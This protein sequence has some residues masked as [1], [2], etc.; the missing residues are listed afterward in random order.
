[1]PIIYYDGN[2]VYC[3]NYCIWLIQHGLPKSY[4]FTT[5]KSESAHHLF[6]Q[7]PEA[8]NKNSVI[9]Q[10][11]QHLE[12]KSNAIASLILATTDYK[13]LGLLLK[14]TPRPIRDWAYNLFA[15]N[16]NRMWKTHWHQPNEYEKT[17]FIDDN[18]D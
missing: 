11:G 3:Y 15:N 4:E 16:R 8:L 17:F 14:V 7:H 6:E 18:R 12:F 13:W 10:R 2:C 9:L 1:M 5:L